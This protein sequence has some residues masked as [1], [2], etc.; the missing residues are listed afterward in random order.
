MPSIIGFFPAVLG[1]IGCCS[2][3]A[4]CVL[5]VVQGGRWTMSRALVLIGA[6]LGALF[7]IGIVAL[8]LA[9]H[10]IPWHT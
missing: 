4:A 3:M 9:S 2:M 6:A 10:G 7:G 8:S 1:A 5:T